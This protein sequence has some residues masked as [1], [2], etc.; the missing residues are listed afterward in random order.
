MGEADLARPA[1]TPEALRRGRGQGG[2]DEG[3]LGG[4]RES[5]ARIERTKLLPLIFREGRENP[6]DFLRER[7]LPDP[8]RSKEE[9]GMA[10]GDRDL[11][12][13][14]RGEVIAA[15]EA[16]RARRRHRLQGRPHEGPPRRLSKSGGEIAR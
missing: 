4:C 8:R 12:R 6:P 13:A 11:E 15:P 2:T 14:A 7:G 5:S 1:A 16:L 3:A 10:A 9:R